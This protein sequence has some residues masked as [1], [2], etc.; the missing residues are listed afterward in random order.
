[1]RIKYTVYESEPNSL[2]PEKCAAT[3]NSLLPQTCRCIAT[4]GSPNEALVQLQQKLI[5]KV[6]NFNYHESLKIISFS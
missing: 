6:V 2:H 4:L 1:M 5:L 3:L